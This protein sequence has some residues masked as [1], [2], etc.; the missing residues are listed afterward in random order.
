MAAAGQGGGER[1]RKRGLCVYSSHGD[2]VRVRDANSARHW[3]FF[4]NVIPAEQERL[5]RSPRH[6]G[7][8]GALSSRV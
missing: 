7:P 5:R 4:R 8:T 2:G 1:R 6:D 3:G